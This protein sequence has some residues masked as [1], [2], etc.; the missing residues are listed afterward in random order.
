MA[1]S[2]IYL[3]EMYPGVSNQ[4]MLQWICKNENENCIVCMLVTKRDL[5]RADGEHHDSLRMV[6]L[7]LQ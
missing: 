5:I 6:S 7:G 2:S 3:M 4:Y 1:E